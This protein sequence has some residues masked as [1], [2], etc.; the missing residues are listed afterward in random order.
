MAKQVGKS[1]RIQT[2]YI[3][4]LT[5]GMDV[6]T[7]PMALKQAAQA[8]ENMEFDSEGE[9]LKTR[10]GLGT[11]IQTFEADIYYVWYDYGMNDYII[12]LK[13]KK[14][15]T[16]EV[17]KAPVFIGTIEGDLTHR[18]QLVRFTNA[19]GTKLLMAVGGTM[20]YYEYSGT[21]IV[22]DEKYPVCDIIME[23]F[24]RVLVAESSNNDIKY[25]GIADPLNWT[26]NSNDPSAMKD[27]EVG[28]VS[29]V[30]GLYP[31]ASEL[32]CFKENGRIYRVANEPEDWNVTLVG[33][34]SDF[35]SRDAVTNLGEDAVYFSRQ[36][37]R[38][39]ETAETYGNF[40][41]DEIGEA[42]NPEMK[43][44]TSDPWMFK[45]QRTHQLFI[46]PNNKETVYVYH[47][48]LGDKSQPGAF[49]K[50]IFPAPVASI[51]EGLENT[52]VAVGTE[53]F[54]LSSTNHTDVVGGK[55]YKIHQ[56]IVSGVCYDLNLMTLYRSHLM[57][58]SDE[59]GS[60]KLTVNEVT[61]NWNWTA[62][63]QREEFKTQ[64]RADQMTFTFE[65]DNIITWKFWDA[66]IVMQ[67]VTMVSDSSSSGGSS[68]G[69]GSGKKGGWGQGT[70]EGVTGD[71][72]GSPYG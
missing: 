12:F 18:P 21:S 52:L 50:W 8:I 14:V 33:T 1:K 68:G 28:D 32:I 62:D 66:I 49:T 51:A 25:S 59:A 9:Q 58:E 35:I 36:G 30:V 69:W 27:L 24:S 23:R 40:T 61:W 39:L 20:H 6:A 37:L 34:D 48:Q 15:Y 47:Y 29:G 4:T 55:E 56:R 22:T 19:N 63:K 26:E 41:N 13:N 10:R 53:L 65:T 67:Y 70:F 11:P 31:L 17:G 45:S 38:S 60:A 57:V 7:D 5:K 2:F 64:I 16:Y 71:S 3:D 44:D 46:N 42:M 43:K 54:S 72:G